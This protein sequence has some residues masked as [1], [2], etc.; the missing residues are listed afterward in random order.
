[1]TQQLFRNDLQAA[2]NSCILCLRVVKGLIAAQEFFKV[3]R[4]QHAGAHP[5]QGSAARG[6]INCLSQI[7]SQGE[8]YQV[9][10][11]PMDTGSHVSTIE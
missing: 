3:Q 5:R 4:D 6:C 1:M 10:T 8:G 9:T 2:E 7:C 11:N